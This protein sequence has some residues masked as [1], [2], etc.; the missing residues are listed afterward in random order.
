M[1]EKDEMN[2]KEALNIAAQLSPHFEC[3]DE[4]IE[5]LFELAIAIQNKYRDLTPYYLSGN[6]LS[7]KSASTSEEQHQKH[8]SQIEQL[9]KSLR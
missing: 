9:Q 5:Q 6:K 3:R 2:L 7:N 8:L 1:S 4:T